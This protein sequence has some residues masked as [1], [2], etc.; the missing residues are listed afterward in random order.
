M[1]GYGRGGEARIG[2]GGHKGRVVDE[3][4]GTL[5]ERLGGEEVASKEVG[6]A[7]LRCL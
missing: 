7:P 4:G 3:F 1:R 5:K 2:G 6:L